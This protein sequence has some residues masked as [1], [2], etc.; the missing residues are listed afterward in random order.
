[1]FEENLRG[2]TYSFRSMGNM[3][4]QHGKSEGQKRK[5]EQLLSHKKL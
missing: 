4:K 5:D 3:L 1:M 2:Y